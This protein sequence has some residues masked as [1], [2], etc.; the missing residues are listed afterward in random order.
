MDG[1]LPSG[2]TCAVAR[3]LNLSS[4]PPSAV[5]FADT[6]VGS[7]DDVDF[8]CGDVNEDDRFYAF[9]LTAPAIVSATLQTTGW[10]GTVAIFAPGCVS[11]MALECARTGAGDMGTTSG[12]FQPGTYYVGVETDDSQPGPFTVTLTTQPSPPGDTC[13]VPYAAAFTG[14]TAMVSGS[15]AG[16]SDNYPTSCGPNATEAVVSFQTVAGDDY[17]VTVGG[18]SAP[19]VTLA[20]SGVARNCGSGGVRAC[21]DAGTASARFTATGSGTQFALVDSASAGAFTATVQRTPRVPGDSCA[22][23]VAIPFVPS[24]NGVSHASVTGTTVGALKDATLS[25]G[26]SAPHDVV[27]RFATNT[28]ASLGLNVASTAIVPRVAVFDSCTTGELTCRARATD[29]NAASD[30][31]V[32]VLNPG[33]HYIWVA[34]NGTSGAFTLNAVLTTLPGE[35]CSVAIPFTAPAMGSPSVSG[36]LTGRPDKRTISGSGCGI[37][38]G[39]DVVYAVTLAQTRTLNVALSRTTTAAWRGTLDLQTACTTNSL[40]S[41]GCVV[42]PPDGGA[43]VLSQRLDAGTYYLWVDSMSGS[44]AGPFQLQFSTTP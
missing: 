40:N 21:Q 29:S 41:V 13:F 1:G 26:P 10:N 23:T 8:D 39:A 3:V 20:A 33:T 19:V 18:V 35:A 15:L 34:D 28:L 7:N 37:T 38:S 5:T 43:A 14:N 6:L 16:L 32:A 11:D 22:A 31:G 25:C 44:T 4:T 2:D 17:A 9:T 30:A 42:A 12:F 36:D 24:A 27:Y